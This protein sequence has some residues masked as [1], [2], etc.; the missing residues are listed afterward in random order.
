MF[1]LDKEEDEDEDED[2][3]DSLDPLSLFAVLLS[4][5]ASTEIALGLAPPFG[6]LLKQILPIIFG[7]GNW[8][9]SQAGAGRLLR[10]W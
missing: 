4:F 1:E 10:Q 2:D 7:S 5:V 3:E 8:M 9:Q 6:C